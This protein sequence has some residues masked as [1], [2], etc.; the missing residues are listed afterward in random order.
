MKQEESK[1][2]VSYSL[3]TGPEQVDCFFNTRFDAPRKLKALVYETSVQNLIGQLVHD[4]RI[5]VFK[6]NVRH[7]LFDGS[8]NVITRL[9][10][11]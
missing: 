10:C 3:T 2:T 9:V 8:D 7:M 5:H 1:G 4:F 6:L 11:R